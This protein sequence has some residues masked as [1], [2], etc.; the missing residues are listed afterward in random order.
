MKTVIPLMLEELKNNHIGE[1]IACV[2][3][4][5]C[6]EVL[7][8]VEAAEKVEYIE[9]LVSDIRDV[10]EK[11]RE[12]GIDTGIWLVPT[13]NL[14]PFH[15][16]T[17]LTSMDGTENKGKCCPMDEEYCRNV[18]SYIALIVKE[19]GTKKLIFEDDFRMHFPHDKVNCFCEHHMKF[20]RE[21]IGRDITR[22]EMA[23]QL[24]GP[25]NQYREAWVK[26]LQA[27]LVKLAKTIRMAV[28]EVNP[29]V[30][31]CFSAGPA[32][33]GADG[34]DLFEL[35]DILKGNHEKV[36]MRLSGGPYWQEGLTFTRN[37]MSAVELERYTAL[38]CKQRGIIGR[39]EGDCFPRPRH[40]VPAAHLEIFHTAL[41][42]DGNCE[43]ILKYM[44]DYTASPKYER[45]YIRAHV[46]NLELYDTIHRIIQDTELVGFNPVED[47]SLQTYTHQFCLTPED[48]VFESCVR[49]F[50][51]D[52]ALPTAHEKGGVNI[53]F[54]DRARMVDLELLR[55]G[56][57]IDIEAA[58]ILMERGI[59]VGI[60]TICDSVFGGGKEY[61]IDENEHVS[62]TK[63]FA[64]AEI[65]V[66]KNARIKS[67]FVS[68]NGCP[69]RMISSYLY[70]SK[71]GFKFLVFNFDAS[72]CSTHRYKQGVFT[73]YCRE[74]M[75]FASY[76]WLHGRPLAAYCEGH[77]WLYTLVRK[78][79]EKCVIGLWNYC[80]DDIELPIV[81]LG[82]T[83][84]NA[85]FVGCD[86]RL[87]ENR[88]LLTS[89]LGAFK[90]CF[91]ELTKKAFR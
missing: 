80:A 6:D 75:L 13:L 43:E 56:S 7:I 35:V 38:K 31:I 45:G 24:Q 59:D 44:V 34:T 41:L 10:C 54:G 21:Y 89:G 23:E 49:N 40:I 60:I 66:E 25:P 11:F 79:E 57:V 28:D 17:H 30:E 70:E 65:Q 46:K 58:K 50:C 39:A 22:E 20:Y 3:Q 72:E 5:H 53:L 2:Q 47:F 63:T 85:R 81:E 9:K 15:Q 83:Y 90:Y 69:E 61:F 68:H 82:E 87:E 76:E 55:N 77:P 88:V 51:T 33:C 78:N 67:Y 74:R 71:E 1:Y 42:F 32:N 12:V 36:T 27:G 29:E 37:M 8:A 62:I 48:E 86:G 16:H 64:C 26:G 18:G 73:N 4:C 52:N 14:I 84:Q 19:T 91:L